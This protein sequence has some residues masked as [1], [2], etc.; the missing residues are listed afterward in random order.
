MLKRVEKEAFQTI[1]RGYNAVFRLNKL[2]L[3]LVVPLEAYALS[4]IHI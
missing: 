1:N 4:L 2:S 3:G